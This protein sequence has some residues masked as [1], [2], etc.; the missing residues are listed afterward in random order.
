MERKRAI[1][2]RKLDEKLNE[3]AASIVA[4]SQDLPASSTVNITITRASVSEVGDA[5][6]VVPRASFCQRV[7]DWFKY[8]SLGRTVFWQIFGVCIIIIYKQ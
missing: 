6:A 7:Q 4:E 3:K 1:A 2:R 5:S 8:P